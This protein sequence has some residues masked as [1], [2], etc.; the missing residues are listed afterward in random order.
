M[1]SLFA[2]TVKMTVGSGKGSSLGLNLTNAVIARSMV[3]LTCGAVT[4]LLLSRA[5][6]RNEPEYLY[7]AGVSA[8][9]TL[10]VMIL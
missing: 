3:G 5:R 7:W 4:M 1:I 8:V 10:L 6:S 9:I 2:A